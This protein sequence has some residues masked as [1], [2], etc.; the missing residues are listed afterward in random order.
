MA[1]KDDKEIAALYE[2]ICQVDYFSVDEDKFDWNKFLTNQT[3]LINWSSSNPELECILESFNK[4]GSDVLTKDGHEDVYEIVLHN[5]LK[6]SL[7][8]N[9]IRPSKA[10][11]FLQ[12]KKASA[13]IKDENMI[14]DVYGQLSDKLDKNDVVCMIMFKD[15]EN[16]T[17]FTGKVGM[18]SRELFVALKNAMLN[19]WSDRNIDNIKIIGMRVDTQEDK[20]KKFYQML[21]DNFLSHRFPNTFVDTCTEEREGYH[22]LFAT[23]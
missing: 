14:S 17:H 12:T 19:S 5:G 11:D 22:L 21:I 8:L 16:D 23:T 13:K 7:H 20:R 15:E 4:T 9:Y 10:R 3:N 1:T 2:S 18:S 6:F